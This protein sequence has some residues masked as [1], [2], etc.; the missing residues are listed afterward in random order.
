MKEH[1]KSNSLTKERAP[2]LAIGQNSMLA[3]YKLTLDHLKML[4]RL[5]VSLL[6]TVLKK[7]SRGRD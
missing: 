4:F 2:L 7:R 3:A 1:V 6:R 5:T